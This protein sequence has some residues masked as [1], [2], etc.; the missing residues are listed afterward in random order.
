[1]IRD[2][3]GVRIVENRNRFGHANTVFAKVDSRLARFIPL[4]AHS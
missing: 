1:M 4:E 3:N 2:G